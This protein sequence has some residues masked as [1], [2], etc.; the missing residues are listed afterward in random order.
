MASVDIADET[1]IVA[2]PA[3]VAA[4]VGDP[5]RWHRWWPDLELDM[6]RD[7]GDEGIAWTVRGAVVGEMEIWL[8][9]FADGV[10][11]HHLL[12]ADAPGKR[13]H[14]WWDARTRAWK[15]HVHR[16]KDELEAGRAPGQA[17]IG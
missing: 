15:R 11:L 4:A 13:S 3:V 7:R 14:R 10:I 1:F 17:R 6:V 16:L 8:E 5:A 9:P 12:R 2:A